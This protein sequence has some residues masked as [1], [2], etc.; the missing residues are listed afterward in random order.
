MCTK[1]DASPVGADAF[2]CAGRDLKGL[3]D[4][5][6]P[7]LRGARYVGQALRAFRRATNVTPQSRAQRNGYSEEQ[8]SLCA[9][10]GT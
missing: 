10:G 6:L 5:P 4:V 7:R 1:K 8:P 2:S 3:S 9:R